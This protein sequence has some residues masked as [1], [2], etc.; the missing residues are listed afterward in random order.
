MGALWQMLAGAIDKVVK[1]KRGRAIAPIF[2]ILLL[3]GIFAAAYFSGNSESF[4]GIFYSGAPQDDNAD[5]IYKTDK[6]DKTDNNRLESPQSSTSWSVSDSG[7]LFYPQ[8]RGKPEYSEKAL[9]DTENFTLSKTVY[10]SRDA[11][12]YALLREPKIKTAERGAGKPMPAAVL[13]PGALVPKEG[14]Q[15][16]ASKLA[17]WGYVTLTLDE[18]GNKGETK[19]GV[20]SLDEDYA[21]FAQGKE[22]IQHKMVFDALRAFDILREKKNVDSDNIIILGESMGGRYGA[23]AAAIEPR[24]KGYVGISTAGYGINEARVPDKSALKFLKSIDPDNYIGRIAPRKAVMIHSTGD[25]VIPI[26]MAEAAFSH[27]KE[28]RKLIAAEC[29]THGFCPEMEPFLKEELAEIFKK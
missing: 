20:V 28:P 12:I 10:K 17:E 24:I 7:I 23:I 11:Y 21:S 6:T 18:R 9:N 15:G 16:L 26:A 4:P 5:K 13:L 19:E 25:A 1:N 3:G 8:N 22:P 27:A 14:Q 29:K 2:F